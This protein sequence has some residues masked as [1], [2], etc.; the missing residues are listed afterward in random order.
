MDL[1]FPPTASVARTKLDTAC[2]VIPNPVTSLSIMNCQTLVINA[3]AR[4]ELR[5][6]PYEM[7]RTSFLP[8]LSAAIPSGMHPIPQPMYRAEFAKAAR[9]FLS[10]TRSNYKANK[11]YTVLNKHN[12]L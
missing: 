9:E 3:L 11:K 12:P 2:P 4:T 8:Y 5:R 6:I 1:Y 7:N 10:Q